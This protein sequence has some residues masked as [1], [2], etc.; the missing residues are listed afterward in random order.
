M[1][2]VVVGSVGIDTIETP[3]GERRENVLGGS[4]PYFAVAASL[5]CP[6]SIVAVAGDDFPKEFGE[7]LKKFDIDTEGLEI[8]EGTKT[9]R[10]GG[11]YLKNMDQRET[12]F[13]EL[14]VLGERPAKVPE[15]YKGA[16]NIF[17]ANTDPKIQLAILNSFPKRELVV[18][19]TM[20]LW[21]DNSKE[22]LLKLL[23]RVDGLVLNY[24]EAEE[25]TGKR[26]AV[27]AAR[28]LLEFGPK[29]V[30]VKKGEHGSIL[31]HKE[32]IAALP[33][34]PAENVV[35]PTGAGDT[36]GGGMMGYLDA[37]SS[38]SLKNLLRAIAYGTVVASFTIEDFSLERLERLTK[39]ELDAR[40]AEYTDM[41][42]L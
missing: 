4:A 35:D 18:A 19:D 6:V 21:I 5:L 32:G 26:N 12:L 9:F 27:S 37:H 38:L 11:K 7:R 33:A 31:A 30:V 22:D 15:S 10:W 42:N 24:D 2:L 17:L 14:N 25:L 8:R 40:F 13:T 36:F 28:H 39:S 20:N 41:L 3:E 34:Y 29:F 23:K 1:A 16:S